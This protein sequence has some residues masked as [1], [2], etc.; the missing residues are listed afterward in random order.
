VFALQLFNCGL[1]ALAGAL[2]FSAARSII[3]PFALV[4]ALV[5]AVNPELM[6]LAATDLLKDPSIVL[7]LTA[8]VWALVRV[9]RS[10]GGWGRWTNAAFAFL[11][12]T[13]LRIDRF[14]VEIYLAVAVVAVVLLV[15]VRGRPPVPA[16]AAVAVAALAVFVATEV[17]T[18]A[19]GWR[20]ATW[21]MSTE[22]A[23]VRRTAKMRDYAPGL[24]A[25]RSE[26]EKSEPAHRVVTGRWTA[27]AAN[28]VRRL[29]GPFVWILPDRWDVAE[30][31]KANY[32]LYPGMLI[33]YAV[34]PLA[35]VGLGQTFW[36][37][38]RGREDSLPL[39]VLAI[40]TLLYFT[41]YLTLNL[42]YRQRATMV[43]VAVVFGFVGLAAALPRR[44]W[45][46]WY[47]G[48]WAA[49]GIMAAAHLAV[50]GLVP[51]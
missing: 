12:A 30:I 51:R 5:V 44:A 40:F 23:H 18:V 11:M 17:A 24:L 8:V 6:M 7:A 42:S 26:G 19:S 29:Y 1:T 39:M 16:G 43:P 46:R 48:Y 45:K 13:Y 35:V 41:Q 14:Y 10:E 47:A 22:I 34:I 36:R 4:A 25:E 32:L 31:L 27:G 28:V 21:M 9:W 3:P 38:L 50:R 49:L 37:T 2:T 15:A 20:P 33:W